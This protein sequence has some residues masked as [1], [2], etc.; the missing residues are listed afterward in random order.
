MNHPDPIFLANAFRSG[1]ARLVEQYLL[2]FASTH[3]SVVRHSN[4]SSVT[5]ISRPQQASEPDPIDITLTSVPAASTSIG[6]PVVPR[7]VPVLRPA[8]DPIPRAAAIVTVIFSLYWQEDLAVLKPDGIYI[9]GINGNWSLRD[10]W[11]L[12]P[13]NSGLF[14]L[15]QSIT[16]GEY[17]FKYIEKYGERLVY[18]PEGRNSHS[19]LTMKVGM[20][21][22]AVIAYR[23]SEISEV[24]IAQIKGVNVTTVFLARKPSIEHAF[25]CSQMSKS[26]DAQRLF[27]RSQAGEEQHWHPQILLNSNEIASN[28][29]TTIAPMHHDDSNHWLHVLMFYQIAMKLG[30]SSA[31]FY[32]GQI[33][34]ECDKIQRRLFSLTY[35]P[36]NLVIL[37][38]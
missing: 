7:A 24:G 3:N 27:Q 30:D 31:A 9:V 34:R 17:Q 23:G 11:K 20:E 37:M 15:K 6:A 1:N 36:Q 5:A 16:S 26:F 14:G 10:E 22:A 12:H 38:H 25:Y 2:Q 21:D 35:R 8:P 19:N 18:L 32:L 13:V 29:L 4:P 28:E 33:T